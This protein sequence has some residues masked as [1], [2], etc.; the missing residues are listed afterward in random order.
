MRLVNDD[1]VVGVQ[2]RVGLRLG[3]QNP[4]SHQLDGSIAAQPVLE[5]HLETDHL[6]EWGFQLFRNTLGHAAGGN[7][8]RLGVTNQF[9]ALTGRVIQLAAPHAERDFWQLCGFTRTGFTADNDNLVSRNGG[10]NLIALSRN[11]Q[12]FRKRDGQ[13]RSKGLQQKQA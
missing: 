1:G 9:G 6:A 12:R 5:A 10:G 13:R 2:Q 3:Q 11:R 7:A 4:V 8:A